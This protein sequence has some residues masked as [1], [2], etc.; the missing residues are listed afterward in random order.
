MKGQES[1]RKRIAREIHDGLGQMLTALK[2]NI[3][4]IKTE[5]LP[6]VES[7]ITYQTVF[8]A[9]IKAAARANSNMFPFGI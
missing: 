3:E 2:M 6:D 1:E 8:F 5:N 9:A 4:S 7:L